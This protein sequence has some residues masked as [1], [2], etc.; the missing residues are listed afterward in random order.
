M[1]LPTW[2]T[3]KIVSEILT[4][5]HD[6]HHDLIDQVLDA[7]AWSDGALGEAISDILANEATSNPRELLLRL[8]NKPYKT[9]KTVFDHINFGMLDVN[10][11]L[12]VSHL[13]S[14][15][16]SSPNHKIPNEM[17]KALILGVEN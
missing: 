4:R 3:R 2:R 8:H 11:Q 15:P 10:R 13:K 9:S 14:V 17:A 1:W 5:C 7:T 16:K 12:V 6:L